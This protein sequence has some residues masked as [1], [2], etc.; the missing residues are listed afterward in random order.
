MSKYKVPNIETRSICIASDN[1]DPALIASVSCYFNDHETYFPVFK[2]PEVISSYKRD[3]DFDDDDFMSNLIGNEAKV[4]INNVLARMNFEKFLLVGLDEMQKSYFTFLPDLK[5]IEIDNLQEVEHKLKFLNKV[6]DGE[7]RCP[8]N[9]LGKGLIAAKR[10]NKLLIPDNNAD[11]LPNQPL[12]NKEGIIII[13]KNNDV[14]DIIHAN[15]VYSIDADTLFIEPFYREEARGLQK[16]LYDWKKH[17]SQEAYRKIE[18]EIRNRIGYSVKFSK[19][20]YATFFTA[21]LPYGLI[22]KNIIPFSHVLHGLRDD[23]FIFYNIF[24]EHMDN[25]FDSALVFSPNP[26]DLGIPAELEANN[27]AGLLEKNNIFVKKLIKRDATVDNLD[28]YGGYY[29]YDILH[30]CSHGGEVDGYY[31]IEEFTD[32]TGNAHKVEY[33]EVVGF[34]P[35]NDK[36]VRV[37][38]KALFRRFDGFKWK[39]AELKQQGFPDFVYEDMRKALLGGAGNKEVVRVKTGHQIYGSCHI[40]CYDSIHQGQFHA[41]A[42]QSF[43]II[44]NNTCSSWLEIAITMIASGCRGYIGTLWSVKN[45]TAVEAANVF[46]NDF[47]QEN[48]IHSFFRM[49]KSIKNDVDSNIYIFW[50][51]HL[52]S[53]KKPNKVSKDKVLQELLASFLRWV[54][55]IKNTILPDLRRSAIDIAKFIYLE[56]GNNFTPEDFIDLK[57]RLGEEMDILKCSESQE[58]SSRG[59]IDRGVLDLPHKK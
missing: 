13:E 29:P 46:Y 48:I 9:E 7:M 42:S 8:R 47:V 59:W 12:Y 57:N 19:Y 51:L 56:I 45:T 25:A 4:L 55:Y 50:G 6:F 33:E 44:F 18:K 28:K 21:G 2:F 58:T 35:Y 27:T 14:S 30:I 43:P 1:A 39:S 22:L 34:S 49:T 3:Y 24:F 26:E 17:N 10:E 40:R 54:R 37:F 20:R 31:V 5:K 16:Y 32:R 41:L 38:R 23:F 11:N 15:Y 53:I 52:S 36:L